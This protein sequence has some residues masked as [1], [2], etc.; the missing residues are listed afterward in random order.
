LLPEPLIK[1]L[2]SPDCDRD[3]QTRSGR[4]NDPW[5]YL[6]YGPTAEE[7]EARAKAILRLFDCG[8]C[9]PMQQR[10]LEEGK[11]NLAIARA[12]SERCAK[13]ANDVDDEQEKIAKPSEVNSEILNQLKAQRV[14]VAVELAGLNARVKACDSMLN[15]PKRLEVSTLQSVSDM[16]VKAEIER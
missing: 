4:F 8:L 5:I 3:V 9:R 11:K 13:L 14:M 16:K 15:E 10:F 7:A 1:Y 2:T 6:V 12:T